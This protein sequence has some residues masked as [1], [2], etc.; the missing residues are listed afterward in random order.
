VTSVLTWLAALSYIN[1]GNPAILF[2]Q[3]TMMNLCLFYLMLSPCGA[4]WSVDALVARYRAARAAIRAGKR[5]PPAGAPTPLVSAGFVTRLIQ[6]NYCLIYLSSGLSKLKGDSWWAGT[7]PYLCMANPEF[8]PLYIKL[9]QDY[10]WLL[11]QNRWVWEIHMNAVTVFTLFTELGLP[12]L[13]WTR[14]RPFMVS[15]AILLHT[16]IAVLMGLNVFGLFMFCLLLCWFPASAVRFVFARPPARLPRLRL[17]FGGK[18][19]EQA[20][21]A[22]LV[23]ALDNWNQVEMVDEAPAKGGRTGTEAPPERL[24]L[25]T[26][27]GATRTGYGLATELSGD[28]AILQPVAFLLRLPGLAGWLRSRY[29]EDGT[30][31]GETAAAGS[32]QKPLAMR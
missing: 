26:E 28:L 4:V 18:E 6:V 5:P 27:E 23:S 13:I 19:R 20:R 29:P 31:A 30:G 24:R 10:L 2:G 22:A 3:D 25:V 32:G 15:A 9:Y 7:A 21:A 17:F 8:S 1:R 16:G 12:F 14:A 11:C